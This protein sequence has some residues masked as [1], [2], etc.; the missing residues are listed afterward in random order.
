MA[1]PVDL[2]EFREND[3]KI[4]A[5]EKAKVA[6]KKHHDHML[7][8]HA[9]LQEHLA[10]VDEQLQMADIAMEAIDAQLL[11]LRGEGITDMSKQEM[12]PLQSE[13][14]AAMERARM[15][16]AQGRFTLPRY[17]DLRTGD[18]AP[19]PPQDERGKRIDALTQQYL[20]GMK[21]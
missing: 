2:R 17:E 7:T 1:K 4:S 3:Q 13:E 12:R 21:Q 11:A 8:H 20:E 16:A 18:G 19:L 14:Y 9:E 5:L 15:F 10:V 6:L